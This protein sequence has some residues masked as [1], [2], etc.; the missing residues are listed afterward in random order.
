[1]RGP[2]IRSNTKDSIINKFATKFA[3]DPLDT[4]AVTSFENSHRSEAPL[5][6]NPYIDDP[7]EIFA[8]DVLVGA[9][10]VEL[11]ANTSHPEAEDIVDSCERLGDRQ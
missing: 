11:I 10:Q 3:P 2:V 9:K 8:W 6:L 1:M 7:E 5:I 4:T